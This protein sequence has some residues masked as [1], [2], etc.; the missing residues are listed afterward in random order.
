M[1]F[2]NSKKEVNDKLLLLELQKGNKLAFNKL[3]EYYWEMAYNNAF[4]FL[5]DTNL[6]KDVV[7]DV[8]VKIWKNRTKTIDNFPGY[9]YI[10]IRNRSFKEIA[11]QK[12]TIP[13]LEHL[14]ALSHME[15][16]ESDDDWQE[17]YSSLEAHIKTLPPKRQKIF[18]LR[19]Q[20]ELNT[21]TIAERLDISRKTVQNQLGKALIQIRALM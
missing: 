14:Q 1:E 10:A 11:K 6:S 20:E 13:Y 19:F 18:R 12:R 8:F 15:K 5:K 7:Q 4:K 9:L 17:L 16:N 21:K 3:Y 2:P